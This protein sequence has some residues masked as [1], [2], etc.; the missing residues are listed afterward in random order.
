ML[1]ATAQ[2]ASLWIHNFLAARGL[3]WV[4][5]WCSID[6]AR[7]ARLLVPCVV[8]GFTQHVCQHSTRSG[9]RVLPLICPQ[10]LAVWLG[11]PHCGRDLLW[12]YPKH[13]QRTPPQLSSGPAP[14]SHSWGQTRTGQC[15]VRRNSMTKAQRLHNQPITPP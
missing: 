13:A 7:H 9:R 10:I 8:A 15:C 4:V 11:V 5:I 6:A 3:L 14:E 12:C 2:S 1:V